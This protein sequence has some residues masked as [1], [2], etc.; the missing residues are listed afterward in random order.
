MLTPEAMFNRD[1]I[2]DMSFFNFRNAV[3]AC[4][5][6]DRDLRILKVNNN[7]YAFYPVLGNVGNVYFPEVL[8]QL[9]VDP[10]QIDAYRQQLADHGRVIIPHISIKRG[11]GELYIA[12][13]TA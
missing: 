8:A 6:A 10:S 1:S 5:F 4:Y 2:L 12:R 3:T 9:G 7:F 13:D 11:M